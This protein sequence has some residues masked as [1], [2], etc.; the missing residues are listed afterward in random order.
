MQSKWKKLRVLTEDKLAQV[1]GGKQG[2][3][4]G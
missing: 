2:Q 3:L 1:S 4:A